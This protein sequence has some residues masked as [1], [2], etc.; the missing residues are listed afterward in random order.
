MSQNFEQELLNKLKE[1]RLV[2]KKADLID[3]AV[4]AE[5]IQKAVELIVELEEKLDSAYAEMAGED[6]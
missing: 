2:P 4:K 3:P 1:Y 5:L 6:Y